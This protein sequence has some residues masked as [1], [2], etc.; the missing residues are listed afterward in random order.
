MLELNGSVFSTI[1]VIYIYMMRIAAELANLLTC[2]ILSTCS[3][4]LY[5]G[6]TF[7]D[8]HYQTAS[9]VLLERIWQLV[10]SPPLK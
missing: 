6:L 10:S 1:V 9:E 8:S 5:A 4:P 3:E 7:P 2:E